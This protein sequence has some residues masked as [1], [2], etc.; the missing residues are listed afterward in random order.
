M[1]IPHTKH[2]TG[3]V[4]QR[5]Y[6]GRGGT[7]FVEYG[8]ELSEVN[9]DGVRESEGQHVN[10][11]GDSA[12]NPWPS[13]ILWITFLGFFLTKNRRNSVVCGFLR[14]LSSLATSSGT[15]SHTPET[16]SLPFVWMLLLRGPRLKRPL[17][18]PCCIVREELNQKYCTLINRL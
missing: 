1:R 3:A 8:E 14:V 4:V 7:T 9:S 11:E 6:P 12:H 15:M 10:N 18:Q 13:S 16:E 17:I 2:P 5:W